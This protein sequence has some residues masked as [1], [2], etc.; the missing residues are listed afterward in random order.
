MDW[1]HV[2]GDIKRL[3]GVAVD[4]IEHT[5]SLA[6]LQVKLSL[7]E[8]ELEEAYAALGK[9]SYEH[10]T[11]EEDLSSLI[12]DAVSVVNEKKKAVLDWKR[13]IAHARKDTSN[14]AASEEA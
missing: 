10:F 11:D 14:T 1:N 13:Q 9:V 12:A 3:A 7:A 2:Y 6:T 5:A 4:K 8:K